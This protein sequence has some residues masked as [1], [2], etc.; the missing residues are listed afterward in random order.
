MTSATSARLIQ[1]PEVGIVVSPTQRC[2]EE[3]GKMDREDDAETEAVLAVIEADTAAYLAR[4]VQAWSEC[5]LQSDRFASYVSGADT[6]LIRSEGWEAFQSTFTTMMNDVPGPYRG[7]VERRNMQITVG[8]DLAW[9]KFDQLVDQ[10]GDPMAPPQLTHEFRLLE[11]HDGRWLIAYHAVFQPRRSAAPG[12]LIEV[13]G[14]GNVQWMSD[15][16]REQLPG[17]E[18]LTVSAGRIRAIRPAWDKPLQAAIRRAANLVS[19]HKYN[20]EFGELGGKATWPVVLG[21]DD[22]GGV[23]VCMILIDDQR[24]YLSFGNALAPERRLQIAGAVFAL[25]AGQLRLAKEIVDG[26]DLPTAANNMEI[27]VNTARTHLR[28]MFEKTGVHSQIALVRVLL[29][30]GSS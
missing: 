9:A 29:S 8:G 26:H 21:E 28:R 23:A 22:A 18:F 6:G 11:R 3:R 5:F 12:P 24:V 16:A 4:D 17:Y 2:H 13:D 1:P 15:Q 19:W 27:T 10:T 25:S 14:T 20:A 7:R 30:A